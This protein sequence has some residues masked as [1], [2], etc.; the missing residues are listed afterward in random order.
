MSV[1]D[2]APVHGTGE[3]MRRWRLVLGGEEADGTGTELSG[4]DL[5]RD[6]V[7]GQLYD[8]ERRGELER[9]LGGEEFVA[10]LTAEGQ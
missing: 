4:D 7:L 6:E 3:R 1:D 2:P 5:R 10:A 9:M 8:A